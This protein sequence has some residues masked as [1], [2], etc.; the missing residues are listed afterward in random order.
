MICIFYKI[1][2]LYFVFET[3][4]NKSNQKHTKTRI[5]INT[6]YI[7]EKIKTR[8]YIHNIKLWY[9]LKTRYTEFI[10]NPISILVT[11]KY[12]YIFK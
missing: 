11:T 3:I 5:F 12:I 8:K 7:H 1:N 10:K 4:I 6:Q 9:I 2:A